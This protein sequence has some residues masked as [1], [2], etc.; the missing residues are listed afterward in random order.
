[1]D[2]LP[3]SVNTRCYIEDGDI[4]IFTASNGQENMAF[5][6]ISICMH[7]LEVKMDGYAIFLTITHNIGF[8]KLCRITLE[9]VQSLLSIA[10]T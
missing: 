3:Q 2:L 7:Y 6:S 5:A 4:D 8:D 9:K 1:M 10:F